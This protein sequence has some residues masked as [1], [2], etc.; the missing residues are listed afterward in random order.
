MPCS[1]AP[2]KQSNRIQATFLKSFLK[3]FRIEDTREHFT[4]FRRKIIMVE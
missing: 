2:E 3:N 1:N 4:F